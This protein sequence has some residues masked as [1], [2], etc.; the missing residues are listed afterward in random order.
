MKR[1]LILVSVVGLVLLAMV[2]VGAAAQI[3]AN[4]DCVEVNGQMTLNIRS[5]AGVNSPVVAQREPGEQI[6]ADYSQV[7]SADGYNWVPVRYTGGRGWA[8]TVRLDACQGN[9]NAPPRWAIRRYR[10]RSTRTACS[11]ISRSR[12]SRAAWC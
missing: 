8:V 4:W 11:T 12:K 10:I 9:N 7:Q 5:A 3:D 2:P 1:W 6:E